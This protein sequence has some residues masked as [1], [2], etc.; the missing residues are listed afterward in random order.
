LDATPEAF[1]IS[2][3]QGGRESG[4]GWRRATAPDRDHL[5]ADIAALLAEAGGPKRLRAVPDAATPH[6]L[7]TDWTG[8]P[9]RVVAR[10]GRRCALEVLDSRRDLQEEYVEWRTVRDEDGRLRRVELTTELPE[11]WA[12]LAPDA[13]LAT[14][15][16]FAGAE[17]EPGEVL[18][19]DGFFNDGPYNDGTRGICCMSQSSNSLGAL[20]ALVCAALRTHSIEGRPCI[21]CDELFPLLG[22]AAVAGRA[23]DPLLVERL[24]R[25]AWEGRLVAF[26][27]PVGVFVLGFEHTR[28]RTWRGEPVGPE[29]F[30]V[31]RGGRRAV[32][33]VPEGHDHLVDVATDS[34]IMHGGQIAELVQVGVHLRVSERGVL[35]A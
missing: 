28:L 27:Q 14:V 32:F 19:P 22:K 1:V 23:S 30:T 9:C 25:V 8:L 21:Q 17:V 7:T 16:E 6:L 2:F 15:R 12:V 24:A 11:Y 34:P 29:C 10:E 13:V 26:D 4:G 5:I 18:D 33:E 3:V 35:P 31:S 20:V